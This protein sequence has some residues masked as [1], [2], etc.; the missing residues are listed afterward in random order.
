MKLL[1]IKNKLTLIKYNIY[2]F[3]SSLISF[4][5]KVL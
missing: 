4:N 5:K 2:K 1:E 3:N